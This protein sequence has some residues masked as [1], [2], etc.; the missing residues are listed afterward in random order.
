V[1][2]WR[3]RIKEGD[4]VEKQR[5][6]R[7]GYRHFTSLTTRWSDN[8]A[9]HHLNNVVYYSLF[10]TAVN[11]ALIRAGLLDIERSSSIG[12]VVET[13]CRYF[14]ALAF[15]DVVEAGVRVAA[16]GRTSVRYEIA[17]FKQNGGDAA[18]QGHF[19]HV[20]VDRNTRQPVAIPQ[21]I[22]SFLETLARGGG[23]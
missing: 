8:D 10:D 6:S 20:Y 12:V 22:R 5:A 7:D 3:P 14:E 13:G 15:P 11:E 9:Y 17:L 21:E 2:S 1:A 19:V 23:S 16:I 4:R 18:A